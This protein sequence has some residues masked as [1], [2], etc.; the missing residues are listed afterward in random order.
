M[1]NQ[2]QSRFV[3]NVASR[4]S[5]MNLLQY[6]EGNYE[7]YVNIDSSIHIR[8]ISQ[9][10]IEFAHYIL[11]GLGQI[12]TELILILLT[13]TAV[14]YYDA[15]LFLFLLLL[16]LPPVLLISLLLKKRLRKVRSDVK[17]NNEQSLQYLQE[18]LNGFVE[19]NIYGKT[20]FFG[21]RYASKQ[22]TLNDHL[23]NLQATQNLPSRLIEL[24]A[25]LGLLILV[26]LSKLWQ[27]P[28]VGILSVGAFL[29]AAYKIIPG[30]V[31]ILNVLAQ[32]KAYEF[33]LQGLVYT[34]PPGWKSSI[35][36]EMP[37]LRS[38]ELKNVSFQY[39]QKSV[40]SRVDLLIEKGDFVGMAG[41]SGRGKTTL[42]NL[43][44]GFVNPAAGDIIFNNQVVNGSKQLY[45]KRIAYVKQQPFV[46]SDSIVKNITLDENFDW[47][48]LEEVLAVTSLDEMVDSSVHGI[49][50][51]IAENGRNISGGQRQRICIARALY[52]D[53]DLIILDEPFNELDRPSEEKMLQYF[54]KL[55]EQGKMI[56]LITHNQSSLNFCDRIISLN[57]DK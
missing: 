49:N 27:Q 57:E 11:Q 43:L 4:I 32:I 42:V 22:K 15:K 10:P 36:E 25:I 34:S 8:K 28:M 21:G 47:P 3:Y 54:R 45:W 56:L 2:A 31:K 52:K 12:C 50:K 41:I 29:A 53:A 37:R 30:L 24:F 39:L 1:I 9:Q 40:L 46:I 48:K 16:L 14:L 7:G 33:T 44:L 26:A 23:A 38:V 19:S 17:Q 6:L 55:A 35:V 5:R 51:Q 20:N 13:I 18:A